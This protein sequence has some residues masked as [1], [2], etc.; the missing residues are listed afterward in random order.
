VIINFIS[1]MQHKL[2]DSILS[3][4][5]LLTSVYLVVL[6]IPF[7]VFDLVVDDNTITDSLMKDRVF[8]ETKDVSGKHFNV[9]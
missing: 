9:H 3:S 1:S 2:S 7:L 8:L 6:G 4:L 5:I